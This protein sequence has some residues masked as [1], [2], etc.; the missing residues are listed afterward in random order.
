MMRLEH[1]NLIK[2]HG[3]YEDHQRFLLLI[4]LV[5]GEDLFDYLNSKQNSGKVFREME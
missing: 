4:E 5:E 2:T 3:Y 1:N